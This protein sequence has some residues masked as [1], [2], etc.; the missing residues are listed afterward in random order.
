MTGNITTGGSF[1][2]VVDYVLGKQDAELLDS[3]G[4]RSHDAKLA[5]KDF[6]QHSRLNK[7]VKVPVMHISLNFHKNDAD[8]LD[9]DKVRAIAKEVIEKMGFGNAQFLLVRHH[10]AGHPH[11]HIITNRID[12]DGKTISDKFC[13]LKFYGIRKEIEAKYPELTPANGKNLDS[14]NPA[15]LKGKDAVKYKIHN[16]INL[17][18]YKSK[19]LSDLIKNLKTNHGIETELKYRRGSIVNIDGIKFHTDNTWVTGSKVDK[20][21][22]YLNL[23]KRLESNKQIN[24]VVTPL[25]QKNAIVPI[26]KNLLTIRGNRN[27]TPGVGKKKNNWANDHEMER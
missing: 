6:E 7:N 11:M 21:C 2:G 4:I 1:G 3:D 8:K 12:N 27:E 19:N 14:I 10:D 25:A 15:K 16:A 5:A 26:V 20:S 9:N 24:P 23:L 22:S 18:I 13:K 17:E